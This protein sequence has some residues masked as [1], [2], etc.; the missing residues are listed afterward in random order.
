[1]N[2]ESQMLDKKNE[3]TQIREIAIKQASHRRTEE[4]GS[5]TRKRE[6]HIYHKNKTGM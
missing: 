2:I 1:M 6:I 5:Q 3:A 4:C